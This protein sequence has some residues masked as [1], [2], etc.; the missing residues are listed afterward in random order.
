MQIMFFIDWST[1]QTSE[2]TSFLPI[3]QVNFKHTI[4][5]LLSFCFCQQQKALIENKYLTHMYY[6]YDEGMWR[7]VY[8]VE[9][10]NCRL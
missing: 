2:E 3:K 6:L 5:V 4:N 10:L 9:R 7:K 1:D 8:K